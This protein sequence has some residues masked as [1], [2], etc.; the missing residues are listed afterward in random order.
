MGRGIKDQKLLE[1]GAV[2]IGC[3]FWVIVMDNIR[4][5]WSIKVAWLV[6]RRL[7]SAVSGYLGSDNRRICA[8]RSKSTNDNLAKYQFGPP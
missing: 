5:L 3:V 1:I 8:A 7:G 6:L 4:W 2:W